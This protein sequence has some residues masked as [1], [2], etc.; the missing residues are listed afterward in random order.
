MSSSSLLQNKDLGCDTIWGVRVAPHQCLPQSVTVPP[1][2]CPQ[3]PWAKKLLCSLPPKLRTLRAD[4]PAPSVS[5]SGVAAGHGCDAL[6]RD[7][8]SPKLAAA[9]HLSRG[10]SYTPG[11]SCAGKGRK[12][13]VNISVPVEVAK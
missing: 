6:R 13:K 12:E 7:W 1:A 10:M 11:S 9:S 3:P 4:P 2:A 8:T 5:F